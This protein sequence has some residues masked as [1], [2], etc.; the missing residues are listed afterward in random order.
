[1]SIQQDIM[2]EAYKKFEDDIGYGEFIG[3]LS[4]KEKLAVLT[5]NLNY[6]VGNG[7]F[8]QWDLNGYSDKGHELIELVSK[9]VKGKASKQVIEIVQDVLN[10]IEDFE[11]NKNELE[12]DIEREEDAD[13][14]QMLQ[15]ELDELDIYTDYFDK[16]YYKVEKA[17]LKEVE[18]ALKNM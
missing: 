4:T 16:Q 14:V 15:E 2:D 6:Q 1:M 5:G 9:Y 7:G 10:E 13:E 11:I 17:F 12:E 3:R 8:S 18:V